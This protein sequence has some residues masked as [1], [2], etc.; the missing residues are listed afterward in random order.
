MSQASRLTFTVTVSADT[1]SPSTPVKDAPPVACALR[2]TRATLPSSTS[3]ALSRSVFTATAKSTSLSTSPSALACP[4][5][6]PANACT[7]LP[8]I[9]NCCTATGL[10]D[11]SSSGVPGKSAKLTAPSRFSIAKPPLTWKK[12]A[13]SILRLPDARVSSPRLPSMSSVTLEGSA[14]VPVDT[15]RFFA[16]KSTR[17]A[18]PSSARLIS[19]EIV[20]ASIVMSLNPTTDTSSAVACSAIQLRGAWF[21]LTCSGVSFSPSIARPNSTP[22]RLRPVA[23]STSLPSSS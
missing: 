22:P 21:A 13:R 2:H 15:A 23:P 14:L 19:T 12:P 9:S 11:S 6:T 4:P 10:S 5:L 18:S 16:A 20:S 7:P 17:L 8:P 1:V 3:C